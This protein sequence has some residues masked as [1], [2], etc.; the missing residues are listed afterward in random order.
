MNKA[1][2]E[3][4]LGDSVALNNTSRFYV[5]CTGLYFVNFYWN[6]VYCHV[7]LLYLCT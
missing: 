7:Y 2:E 4:L 6:L 5:H 3:L 1:R